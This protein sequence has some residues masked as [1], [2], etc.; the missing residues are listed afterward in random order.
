MH[1]PANYGY[2]SVRTT[3]PVLSGTDAKGNAHTFTNVPVIL[4]RVNGTERSVTVL[5]APN[6]RATVRLSTFK[7]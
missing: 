6:G 4:N 3:L 2:T 1:Q 7:Y 5:N